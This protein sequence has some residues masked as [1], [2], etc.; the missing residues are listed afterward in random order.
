MIETVGG[1]YTVELDQG[2]ELPTRL[3]GR[4]KLEQRTGDRVVVGDIVDVA[5]REGEEATI[6]NVAPRR[7]ELARRAPGRNARKAKV[8]VAN[9]EQVVVVFAAA[10]PEPRLRMLDRFLVLA[11]LNGLAARI[12][13]NKSDAVD[14]PD[15]LSAQFAP[16]TA[17]G[18]DVLFTSTKQDINLDRFRALLCGHESVV[19]G[20]S[21]VGKSSLLNTLEPGLSLRVGAV[22]E[23]VNKGRH[24]TVSARLIRLDCGGHVVDTPGLREVGLWGMDPERLDE[25]FPEFRPYLGQ[26]RFGGSCTHT[27]EPDCAVQ[28]AV[29]EGKVSSERYQSYRALLTD[30]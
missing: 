28:S 4:L 26:C 23:A 19:A 15:A 5:E 27:H 8:I 18:Y 14:D 10:S 24:T 2:R 7:T 25:A 12:V 22:S 21:G 30:E 16:Y 29:D 13:I 9:V 11:E 20:P 3:R 6:E 1:V 17:A